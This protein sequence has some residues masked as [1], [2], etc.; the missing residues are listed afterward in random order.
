MPDAYPPYSR[1]HPGDAHGRH[2]H[3]LD[4]PL[5][6]RRPPHHEPGLLYDRGP[7]PGALNHRRYRSPSP[8]PHLRGMP[9][10]APPSG[11]DLPPPARVVRYHDGPAWPSR[12][13]S[14]GPPPF[15]RGFDPG[16]RAS[17][18]LDHGLGP[19]Y[20][21][22]PPRGPAQQ[23]PSPPRDYAAR[24]SRGVE[25]LAGRGRRPISPS[26]PRRSHPPPH[27][28]PTVR[29]P[30]A[31]DHGER[32]WDGNRELPQS[33]PGLA[34]LRHSSD[35]LPYRPQRRSSPP[36]MLLAQDELQARD[37]MPMGGRFQGISPPRDF[38]Y[39][40]AL[41]ALPPRGYGEGGLAPLRLTEP[42]EGPT[43]RPGF[44][45][46]ARAPPHMV[47]RFHESRYCLHAAMSSLPWLDILS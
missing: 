46:H 4:P 45:D 11:R 14:P 35:A 29:Y 7:P 37:R 12:A 32:E 6:A 34:P 42:W 9:A 22:D 3:H 5:P 23:Y 38:D 43:P 17:D 40:D 30:T 41:P 24:P 13:A 16:R 44:R 8:P 1:A 47:D 31:S 18:S 2:M 28:A 33:G 10:W 27:H 39:Q 26:P 36:R 20:R 25:P 21:H 15:P 19:L